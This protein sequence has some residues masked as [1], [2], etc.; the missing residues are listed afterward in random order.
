MKN[1][2]KFCLA[3]V[4][5]SSIAWPMVSGAAPV[6]TAAT[7]QQ[8]FSGVSPNCTEYDIFTSQMSSGVTIYVCQCTQCAS[9]Y[10]ID[11][12]SSTYKEY[13][14]N[15]FFSANGCAVGTGTGSSGSGSSPE[16][17]S[18]GSLCT[19]CK[20]PNVKINGQVYCGMWADTNATKTCGSTELTVSFVM[21][22]CCNDNGYAVGASSGCYIMSCKKTGFAPNDDKTACVCDIGYYGNTTSCT[23]C[24]AEGGVNGFTTGRGKSSVTDCYIPAGVTLSDTAGQYKYGQDCYY[25]K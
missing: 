20:G 2:H 7:C 6:P 4:A 9:G 24:P 3:V 10:H 22:K 23:R 17:C 15:S 1:F 8:V 16:E 11:E 12:I 13:G 21:S 18:T 25:T 14:G 19:T 5:V